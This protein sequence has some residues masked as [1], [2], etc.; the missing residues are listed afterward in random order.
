MAKGAA[1]LRGCEA[2]SRTGWIGRERG[3]P[4]HPRDLLSEEKLGKTPASHLRLA[5]CNLAASLLGWKLNT[6]GGGLLL[7]RRGC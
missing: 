2:P 5:V 7:K 1:Y 4:F 6:A 3:T